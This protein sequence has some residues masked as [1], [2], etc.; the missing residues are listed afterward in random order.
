VTAG[1]GDQGAADAARGYLR[2][3]HADREHVIDVLKAAFVQGMLSKAELDARVGQAFTSRTH[4]DLAA[5]TAD[6]PAGLIR[7]LPPRKPAPAQAPPPVNKPL[8]W[9]AVAIMLAA[10]ASI[11]AGFPAQNVILLSMGVLAI[12]I[13]APIAGTLML[14]SWRENRSGGQLPPRP[15]QFGQTLE[16]ERDGGPGNDLIVCQAH[17]DTR[18]RRLLGHSVTQRTWR[19]VPTRRASEG[20]C[21]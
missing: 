3:S 5:I 7:A 18:A 4:G 2:T 11:V 10:I 15:A 9:T 12:L 8:M 14:D 20:L 6:L 17:R 16:G 19:S 21:T 13:A 1:P